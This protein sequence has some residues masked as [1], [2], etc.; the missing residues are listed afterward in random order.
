MHMCTYSESSALSL[1]ETQKL[2]LYSSICIKKCTFWPHHAA[3]EQ[4]YEETIGSNIMRYLFLSLYKFSSKL[5]LC[6][7]RDHTKY[8]FRTKI[9][10]LTSNCRKTRIFGIMALM[11]DWSLYLHLTLCK[12]SKKSNERIL[13]NFEK[14]WFLGQNWPF[15]PIFGT[16]RIFEKNPALSLL[17]LHDPLTLYKK[18][19][20]NN[21]RTL[22][23][24]VADKRT[25]G[26]ESAKPGVQ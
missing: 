3:N 13:R 14:C 25:N 7:M 9:D 12:I 15:D 23:Y 5:E 11:S 20:K 21:E 26:D 2:H 4:N 19:E 8:Q 6:S 16:I 10:F 1:K 24:C 18:S 22:R 17:F